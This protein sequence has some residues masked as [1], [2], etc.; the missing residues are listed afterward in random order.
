MIAALFLTGSIHAQVIP[1]KKELQEVALMKKEIVDDLTNNVLAFWCKYAPSP[2][3]GFYGVLRYDGT[4]RENAPKGGILNARLLWT[5]SSAYRVLGDEKYRELADR[6]QR[7]FISNFIDKRYGGTYLSLK[8]DG[9]PLDST[10]MTYQNAFA[11]YGLAEHYRATGNLESLLAAIDIY[12]TLVAEAYDPVNGGFIEEYTR[13]WTMTPYPYP[14]TMNTNLH[15]LEALTGLYR[16]WRDPGL[17]EIFKSEIDVMANKV[18]NRRTWHEQLYMSMDWKNLQE[19]DSYGHDIEF[20]WLLYEAAEVLDDEAVLADVANVAVQVA[21]VQMKEG[22]DKHGGLMYEKSPENLRDTLE[23]WPQAESVTG[24][25]NA[26][27]LTGNKKYLA[28]AKRSW[29]WIKSYMID[30][31]Y[32]EWYRD[33]NPDLTPQKEHNKAD[34]WRCPYHNTRMGFEIIE[35]FPKL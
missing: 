6:A 18:L 33:V 17:R 12:R 15:V 4:P 16:V 2:D 9:T 10:K 24:Y 14:K 22:F 1:S 35:R 21:D 3:G 32:G 27:Q 11:I 19:V 8:A 20:S 26:W 31:E 5:F 23:W 13:N 25:I 29:N 28:T 30:R 7:Y 34:Q